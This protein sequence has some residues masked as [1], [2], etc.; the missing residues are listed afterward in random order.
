M[1]YLNKFIS[2]FFEKREHTPAAKTVTSCNQE[3]PVGYFLS[4]LFVIILLIFSSVFHSAQAQ[5]K[6]VVV[7]NKVRF[8]VGESAVTELDIRNRMNHIRASKAP[9][10]KMTLEKAA[11]SE[12]ITIAIVDREAAKESV[13]ISDS[14]IDNEIRQRM[15]L[16]GITD[17][18]RFKKDVEKETGLSFSDWKEYMRY[19]LKKRQLIQ[20][21]I[22]VP[23]PEDREVKAFY[24]KN[25]AQI[26]V[27]IAYREIILRPRDGSIAEESRVS[28]LAK[29]LQS[30]ISRNPGQFGEIAKT[31]PDNVSPLKS[32]GGYRT[33][34][35][36]HEIAARDRML[37]GMLYNMRVKTVSSVFRDSMNRYMI[38]LVEEKRPVSLEKVED[39]IRNR[40]YYEKLEKSFDSWVEKKKTEIHVTEYK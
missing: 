24:N 26:G 4:Q 40:L 20:I 23:P 29:N 2:F 17:M 33:A 25:K 12:L 34:T 39:N 21:S 14:R 35:P 8:I 38:V 7:V 5:D 28:S 36:I 15:E 1:N 13:I 6:P 16:A 32:A 31:T 22:A 19:Q 11:I 3:N 10:G 9:L 18:D 37:A 27:E 30:Q